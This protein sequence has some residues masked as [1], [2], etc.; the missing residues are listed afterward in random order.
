LIGA[1]YSPSIAINPVTDVAVATWE[2][3]GLNI[4]IGACV[5]FFSGI[6]QKSVSLNGGQSWSAP[7]TVTS[8]LSFDPQIAIGPAPKVPF[9]ILYQNF[10]NGTV[11]NA[12]MAFAANWAWTTSS[13]NG[14]TW[15]TPVD[16][17]TPGSVNI[18]WPGAAAPNSFWVAP[19]SFTGH[20]FASPSFAIDSSP[21]STH[22][23]NQ[24]VTWAD[25]QTPG[26][27]DAG[28]P[29]I[30][31]EVRASGAPSWVAT[32]YLTPATRTTSYFEPALSVAPDGTVWVSFYG[33]SRSTG[34]MHMY[35]VYSTDGGTTWSA[36]SEI[37][38]Q[39]GV[40]ASGLI[41]IGLQNGL[42]ATTAG[43]YATWMDCRSTSCTNNF[44]ETTMIS[45]VEPVSLTTAAA[46]INVTVTTNGAALTFPLPGREAWTVGSTHTV[47]APGWVPSPPS[48][49]ESFV[50]YT[51]A[52]NST[53][54]SATFNYGGGPTLAVNYALVPASFIAGFFSPNT[55]VSRLT[56]DGYN[57]VLHPYNA[58]SMSYNYS[59]AS[60]RSYYLNGSASNL[61]VPLLNRIVGTTPSRTT[62]VD[63]VLPKTQGWLAGRVS[64]TNATLTIDG[65]AV[66]V[67]ATT[68]I[69]NTSVF[70][71]FH[72]VNVSGFGVTNF[73]KYV[74]VS[75]Y[76]TTTTSVTLTGGWIK[77]TLTAAYPGVSVTIDGT[78]VSS[79]TGV[80]FNKSL[81][82]GTHVVK[83]TAK[84]YNNST[85][86]VQVTPA[87]TTVVLLNLTNQGHLVG[88]VSP[89]AALSVATLSVTNL[90][91]TGSGNKPIDTATG[92]FRVQVTGDANW[93]VTVKAT[94]YVTQTVKVFVTPGADTSPVLVTLKPSGTQN[95]TVNCSNNNPPPTTASGPSLLLI[96]GI[97]VLVVLVAAVAAVV[98]MRRRGGGGAREYDTA[99][100]EG[101]T[102]TTETTSETYGSNSYGGPP[103]PNQ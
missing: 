96:A 37:T 79:F 7:V 57:V 38:T 73:S 28:I 17:G 76:A 33:E 64:P 9:T 5:E 35:A 21:T 49:V 80:T 65:Q 75:P 61:Y 25:N 11:D 58:S 48:S 100:P 16:I 45:L 46:G 56:I 89:A 91:L 43:T 86:N 74:N 90:S 24:Y 95:C 29:R 26:S 18:M 94:G 72:W 15:S 88:T 97:I 68:G 103:P 2:M 8:N 13:N 52:V 47:A 50:N 39:A 41:S 22:A 23:G 53:S 14:T 20:W 63:I 87:H 67:N 31:F 101:S 19:D 77:G 3:L 102:V 55:S 92:N 82:G 36:L 51:G 59:V 85:M 81:L 78:A 12:T 4:D 60:G 83:T 34:D 70:W 1:P 32:T 98:L 44:N 10:L 6:V 30:G 93:T 84:G 69:Y 62:L 71:G 40:L 54:F 27:T 66:S 99:P 42:A